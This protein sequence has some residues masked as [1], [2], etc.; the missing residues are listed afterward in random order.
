MSLLIHCR[1]NA[2]VLGAI[3]AIWQS[4]IFNQVAC[5]DNEV[6]LENALTRS[7]RN[8]ELITSIKF[9]ATQ[10]IAGKDHKFV[11]SARGA[12]SRSEHI[13]L[14]SE[15]SP[16][17]IDVYGGQDS[18]YKL[19][20]TKSKILVLSDSPQQSH[21]AGFPN[22][23]VDPYS[24]L[25]G[26]SDSHSWTEVKDKSRWRDAIRKARFLNREKLDSY[27]VDVIEVRH[28][29][30]DRTFRV[31]LARDFGWLPVRWDAVDEK[32][33]KTIGCVASDIRNFVVDGESVFIP[34]TTTATQSTN[35]ASQ[36]P[37]HIDEAS[38]AVNQKDD[39]TQYDIA[40]SEVDQIHD[41]TSRTMRKPK[42]GKMINVDKLDEQ[43]G[44]K[45][46]VQAEGSQSR[47]SWLFRAN[48]VVLVLIAIFIFGRQAWK[49]WK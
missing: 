40:E 5:A 20:S 48:L 11:F 9:V 12:A 35:V 22:P 4:L 13:F 24:W 37:V 31:Y 6:L 39:D 28:T 27:E 34:L 18:R 25:L 16:A 32:G 29:D 30:P 38:L 2:F 46:D 42:T 41:M 1:S 17:I 7:S 10:S 44:T 15:G 23:L 45:I 26:S 43:R 47:I 19:F 8:L 49:S 21:P 36:E 14:S 33:G 3:V